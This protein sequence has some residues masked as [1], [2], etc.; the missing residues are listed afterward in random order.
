MDTVNPNGSYRGPYWGPP[1]I[2]NPPKCLNAKE[3]CYYAVDHSF[4]RCG[5]GKECPFRTTEEV[6]R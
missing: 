4:Q 1:M 3:G 2:A 5:F 6:S